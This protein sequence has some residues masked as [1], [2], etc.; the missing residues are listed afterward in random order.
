MQDRIQG[1]LPSKQRRRIFNCTQINSYL[2]REVK[3]FHKRSSAGFVR[4]SSYKPAE[5]YLS[6]PPVISE[7]YHSKMKVRDSIC[8]ITCGMN[9]M[10]MAICQDLLKNGA[11]HVCVMDYP[12][13]KAE[14]TKFLS[15]CGKEHTTFLPCDMTKETEIEAC[16]KKM[17]DTHKC[18]DIV[19]NTCGTWDEKNWEKCLAVNMGCVIRSCLIAMRFMSKEQLGKGGCIVNVS[20]MTGLQLLACAPIFSATHCGLIGFGRCLGQSCHV[21]KTGVAVMTICPGISEKKISEYSEKLLSFVEP[22]FAVNEMTSYPHQ[23]VEDVSHGILWMIKNCESGCVC[24]TEN[25]EPLCKIKF[26][27]CSEM[28]EGLNFK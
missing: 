4:N 7:S 22:K 15:Q 24:V 19:I 2:R 5:Q 26:L 1:Y 14:E 23:R 18:L 8:L 27:E 20:S 9:D 21:D 16:F 17:I 28:K 12:C 3:E 6:E 13:S 10:G 25:E 11:T